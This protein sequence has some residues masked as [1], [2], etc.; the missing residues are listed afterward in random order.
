MI[1]CLAL[2]VAFFMATIRLECSEARGFEQHLD[3]ACCSRTAAGPRRRRAPA[4]GSKVYSTVRSLGLASTSNRAAHAFVAALAAE[5]HRIDRQQAA[6]RWASIVTVLTKL[7]KATSTLLYSPVRNF[8]WT[9]F[10]DACALPRKSA[11]SLT[12]KSATRLLLQPSRAPG[13]PLRPI[14][15]Y[16]A[17]GVGDRAD[18]PS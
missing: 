15:T 2:S 11:G 3:R 6:R 7:L 12:E 5:R 10:A 4:L 8:S 13:A 14:V 16:S 17:S 1:I 18:R 9:N